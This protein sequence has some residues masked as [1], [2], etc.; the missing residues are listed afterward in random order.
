MNESGRRARGVLLTILALAA[1]VAGAIA[2][3]KKDSS[4]LP[5]Y[6]TGAEHMLHGGEVYEP[7]AAKP[8]T[9]PP[10][11]A[12]PFLPFTRLDAGAQRVIW[13][14]CN[15]AMLGASLVL[16]HRV[17][18]RGAALRAGPLFWALVV[19]FSIRHLLAVFEN[20]SHD[21][22]VLLCLCI[23]AERASR[24]REMGSGSAMGLA[25]A[26]KATPLLFL[27]ALI[28]QR[29]GRAVL[30]F[31]VVAAAATLLPDLFLPRADGQLWV[32]AWIR[33]FAGAMGAGR[34]AD[35][36]H[37]WTASNFLNQNLAGTLHRL[38]L[39]P[40]LEGEFVRDVAL[41]ELGAGVRQA[42]TLVAQALVVAIVAWAAW[43]TRA[44]G[45]VARELAWRRF[46]EIGAIAC[47]MLLLSPM[48]SKS[49]FCVLLLPTT[50]CIAETIRGDAWRRRPLV[51]ALLAFSFCAATLSTKGLIGREAGNLLLAF[52]A[53]AWG[54]FALLLASALLLVPARSAALDAGDRTDGETTGGQPLP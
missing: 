22:V 23:A 36:G 20:Q 51:T 11:F 47:A 30:G 49:H 42:V 52:G 50:F 40:S 37:A 18:A 41:V 39:H 54:T 25:A 48:S 17:I 44:R 8:F 13:F 45:L 32:T 9:Y 31:A 3:W 38:T 15:V 19:A 7:L 28:C 12:L 4:E 5:V 35:V 43:P 6:V 2:A 24:A 14:L 53:V 33:T 1:V 21:L 34:P 10:F 27:P 26:C 29:R 16:L 46:G